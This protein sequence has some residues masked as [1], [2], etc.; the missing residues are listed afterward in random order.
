M[1]PTRIWPWRVNLLEPTQL[2]LA[3][4]GNC[5]SGLNTSGQNVW[6]RETGANRT[7]RLGINRREPPPVTCRER[8]GVVCRTYDSLFNVNHCH[9]NASRQVRC[10][11]VAINLRPRCNAVFQGVLLDG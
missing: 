8:P 6:R 4:Y 5:G 3:L 1:P 11:H 7:K 2:R 9:I 10:D